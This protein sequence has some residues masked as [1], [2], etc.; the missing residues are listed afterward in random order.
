MKKITLLTAFLV[1]IAG[2][3]QTSKQKIQTYLDVN[4]ERLELTTQDVSDWIVESEGS[5]EST[6]INTYFIKQRYQGIEIF[7]AVSNVWVKNNEII[8]FKNRFVNSVAQKANTITAQLTVLEGL[9]KAFNKLNVSIATP[10]QILETL[11]DNKYKINNGTLSEDPIIAQ[12]VFQKIKN[13]NL[14]LAWDLLFYTQDYKHLWSIRVDAV[15]GAI[16]EQ[17]DQVI[18]CDFKRD[19]KSNVLKISENKFRNN[20]FK[21]NSTQPLQVLSGSYKVIPYN[22]ISPDH[23]PF[24]LISNPD[25]ALAS[26]YGWHDTNGAA[27]AE[28]TITRGN[29]VWSRTDY[30]GANPTVSS[31]VTTS[32]G[33]SPNGGASLT[34]DYPYA[35]KSVSAQTSVNAACTNLFYMNNISHDI[36]YQY[37]FNEANGNYQQNNYGRGGTAAD[38]VY[39]DV[40]DGS[41][42]ATPTVDNANFSPQVDG[43]KGRMQMYL[44]DYQKSIMPLFVTAPASILGNYK[45]RQNGFSPGHVDLPI[46]PSALQSDLVLFDDGTPDVGAADNADACSAAVNAAAINGHIVLIRRSLSTASGGTPCNFTVKVKN[47]Q[48]AGAIGVIIYNNIDVTDASG[49]PID[50]PIGM[51]GADGTITIPAIGVSKIVGEMLVAKLIDGPVNV[52]LQLP[53]D[54]VPFVNSDG[55]FDNGVIAHEY[56]HGVSTRLT[57]GPANSSCLQN[58]DQA[59]EGWSD[60]FALMLQLKPGDVGSDGRGVGTF[61]AN[62]AVTGGGIRDFPYSTDFS[63]NPMTYTYTNN[64]QYTDTS[65]NELTEIHGT[66][67]VW[68]SVLWD[69]TWAYIAKYG[70]DDNIYTGTGGNNKIMR[71]VLDGCK[72]QPC[73]PSFID[74]R[75]AIIAA[76]QATTGGVDYCMIWKVFAKR[77]FGVNASAGDTNIGND[78]IQDFTEPAAGPNCTLAVNYFENNDMIRVFPN[79]SNGLYNIR[80]NQFIG[81]V[82]IQVVDI[83]GRVILNNN[84]VDFNIEKTIDLSSFQSGMYILKVNGQELNFSQKLIKN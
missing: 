27:G 76:D 73:S 5:S 41:T 21:T 61:V 83:N 29:N 63:V 16:L 26:P 47:A 71:L 1:S 12:L 65:G 37:G 9:T 7:R 32:N 24:Q 54:Y 49:T 4:R 40:Q 30:T 3:A 13:N 11:G 33:Y 35:G 56:G 64:Y 84:N 57:G 60:W 53:A 42:A 23:S 10:F 67:S 70:Y 14:R 44:W 43:Q 69:L 31:T 2:F 79:P 82:N 78:Q 75:D 20:F 18:S 36:W 58:T 80:I 81:K 46:A 25:N 52:K 45:G 39:G 62:Q 48:L 74:S 22:Y 72:L 6:G 50:V 51:S 68:T 77:G 28:Y 34:F 15:N 19:L 55:D 38:F 59:G 66:G 8:D 17:N